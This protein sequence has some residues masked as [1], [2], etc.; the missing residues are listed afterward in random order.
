MTFQIRPEPTPLYLL[1]PVVIAAVWIALMSLMKEPGRRNLSALLV[2]GVGAAYLSGGLG[3]VEAAACVGFTALAY[4]GLKDYRFIGVAWL[5]HAGWD[6]V[7]HLY[8]NP[9]LPFEPLSSLGCA[10]T[11]PLVAVWYFAGAPSVWRLRARA[12]P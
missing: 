9:I 3:P 12:A 8:A 4:F 2:A 1:Q 10:I 11:D 5:L 7:H 6:V